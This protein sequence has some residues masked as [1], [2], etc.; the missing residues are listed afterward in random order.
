MASPA[1]AGAAALIRQYF[2]D[3]FYP[4]GTKVPANSLVPSG[5]LLRAML[6]NSAVDMTAYPSPNKLPPNTNEGF[7]RILLDN[8]VFL[9]GDARKLL[10]KDIRNTAGT[11]LATGGVSTTSFK[12]QGTTQILRITMAFSDAPATIPTSFAPVNNINL[13]VVDPSG[14]V[15]L[16]NV[17][18][19]ASGQSQIGGSADAINCIE[20]FILNSPAVGTWRAEVVGAAV[21][22][23]TQGFGLVITGDVAAFNP[24]PADFNNDLV[25]DDLDFTIFAIAYET[26]DCADPIMPAG[27]PA[28]LVP[29]A[30]VDD[31]DFVAFAAAYDGFN[32]P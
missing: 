24:C 20:H 7:G 19:A 12:V 3:G 2:T 26:F 8:S 21:N 11:A 25:V 9:V 27:C 17:I 14:N 31:A 23:G 22:V 16:G 1:T 28:D 32:C 6:V 30:F 4:T 29:T 5:A 15:Y 10:I 18:N 13:R